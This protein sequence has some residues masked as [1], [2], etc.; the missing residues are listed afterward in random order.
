MELKRSRVVDTRSAGSDEGGEGAF[1]YQKVA[2]SE[3][4]PS[5]SLRETC[6]ALRQCINIRIKWISSTRSATLTESVASMIPVTKIW[7]LY[8]P[9]RKAVP[10]D[11][12]T[13]TY[14]FVNGV[15]DISG[16]SVPDFKEFVRD[17]FQVLL[18]Q[19]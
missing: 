14:K 10:E 8:D 6:A 5:D 11:V 15:A 12:A 2:I 1:K 19:C 18:Y 9:L 13:W 4:E 3:E 17:Y 16:I 7:P